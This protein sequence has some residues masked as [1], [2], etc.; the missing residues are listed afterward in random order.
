SQDGLPDGEYQLELLVRGTLVQRSS[1]IVGRGAAPTPTPAPGA[2]LEVYGRITDA[3][4]GRGIQGAAF[5]VL[6]PGITVDAFGW[7]DEEVYTWAESDRN[8]A[9]ELPKP[10]VRGETYSIIVAAKGYRPIAED[11]V[12]ISTDARAVPSPF[13]LNVTLQRAK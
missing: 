3:D 12:R 11:G 10:L 6:M 13:E 9:Y 5:I 4:T 1:C 8:G 7:T 2:G